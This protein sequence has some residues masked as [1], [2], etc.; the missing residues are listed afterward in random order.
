MAEANPRAPA[1]FDLHRHNGGH[2]PDHVFELMGRC[3]K[4]ANS[5]PAKNR[6][7]SH[8]FSASPHWYDHCRSRHCISS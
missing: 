3:T 2:E 8:A 5:L 6:R 4:I 1:H 7:V